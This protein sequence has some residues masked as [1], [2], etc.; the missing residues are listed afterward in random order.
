MM[1]TL[2][3]NADSG[4]G[5]KIRLLFALLR[6]AHTRIEIDTYAGESRTPAY[7]ARNANGKIPL[8]ELDD[9]SH[10]AESGAILYRFAVS[11]PFWPASLKGQSEALQWMFFEQY[12]HEPYVAVLRSWSRHGPMTDERKAQ[13]E[14]RKTEGNKALAIMEAHLEARDW[15]AGDAASIADIALFAYT[16]V[17]GDGG[18]DLNQFPATEAWIDRVKG[19]SGFVSFDE[20]G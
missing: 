3:D 5:Y 10:L 15:F 19:L 8:V 14:W 4:N 1:P 16:H 12:S 7:L 11:T 18:F 17:A 6:L 13:W 2:F 20:I 9:G